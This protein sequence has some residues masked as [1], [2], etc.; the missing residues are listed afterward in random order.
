MHCTICNFF[1]E[2]NVYHYSKENFDFP[3]CR[4][5]QNGY[6]DAMT[7]N[8]STKETVLLFLALK[9][10]G[11]AAEIEKFDGHKT[12]DIAVTASRINIEVD[13][14]HHNHNPQQALSDLER[15]YHSFLKGFLTFR[16]PNSL[17]QHH[18]DKT[19][20]M[21]VEMLNVNRQ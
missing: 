10:R 2:E 15:T 19:A 13:G 8:H 5:C 3:L 11:V 9:T 6:R 16:I 21:I 20:D 1:L 7:F 12:I 18:F 14:G 17:V 4:T